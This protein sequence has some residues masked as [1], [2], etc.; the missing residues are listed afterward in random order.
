MAM[1]VKV[2]VADNWETFAFDAAADQTVAGI[3]AKALTLSRIATDRFANYEVKFGGA[4][5]RDESRTMG[6]LG[7]KDGSAF[8]ILSKRRR[9]VR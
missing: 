5:V 3:K 7:V 2:T 1:P 9:A 6:A 4:A 8:I